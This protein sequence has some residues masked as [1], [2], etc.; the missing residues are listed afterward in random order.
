M[1]AY[2]LVSFIGGIVATAGPGAGAEV[3]SLDYS[4][5]RDVGLTKHW[6]ANLPLADGD[7]VGKAFLVEGDLYVA[8]DNGTV[9]ALQAEV[10]LIRW[11][12]PLS[13]AH[14]RIY[15]PARIRGVDDGE[16]LVVPTTT[17]FFIM[18]RYS[19]EVL[20]KFKPPFAPGS[21]VVGL[22]N[23]LFAG[24]IDGSFYSYAWGGAG[25]L[26]LVKRWQIRTGGPVTAAPR[27]YDADKVLFASQDGIVYSCSVADKGYRWSFRTG[28]VILGNPAFD[29]GSVYVASMDRSLYSLD[30]QSGAMSWRLR[31][32]SPL[33]EGPLVV[34]DTVYQYCSDYGLIAVDAATGAERWRDS[35]GLLL[36]AHIPHRDV[37]FTA[38]GRLNIVDHQT[39]NLLGSI[40]A[41][42]AE[43][44]V[45]NA[46]SDAVFLLQRGGRVICLRPDNV[47]Y[48]R[49]R[50]VDAARA[51]LRTP[52]RRDVGAAL[53]ADDTAT[54]QADPLKDDPLRS[55]RDL[56]P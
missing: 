15:T 49:P 7:S 23:A 33:N 31:L 10:G 28:G 30:L 19:G 55:R 54:E 52:P 47:P 44:A 38:G 9:F 18:D 20:G 11:G 43:L 39:G 13:A 27:L 25:D 17:N 29:D 3:G 34:L 32:P 6:V 26:Q 16:H 1:L 24:S 56:R 35:S 22:E 45:A 8:T 42:P 50:E 41:A 48:L 4:A 40:S 5:L 12:I 51:R 53:T 36:A 46:Q 21:P 2:L 37:V 14:H